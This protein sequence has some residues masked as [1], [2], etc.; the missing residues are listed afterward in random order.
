MR[1]PPSRLFALA[2]M[3]VAFLLSGCGSHRHEANRSDRERSTETIF[4]PN[5]EPLNGGPLGYPTCTD[6]MTGWFNRVDTNHDRTIDPSEFL[7]DTRRQ[8]AV[9]DLDHDGEITPDELAAYRAPY[10][11][12][13]PETAPR[14][15][16]TSSD[17]TSNQPSRGSRRGR[18]GNA[19][20]SLPNVGSS[21]RKVD[22]S[23]DAADPVMSADVDLKFRVTLSEFLVYEQQQFTQLDARHDQHLTLAEIL[24]L[25]SK[26]N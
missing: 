19:G 22:L 21:A 12:G 20:S 15:A 23:N 9:M 13:L 11:L 10:D 5:G 24:A 2:A 16:D 8:F 14:D 1:T 6:A 3:L 26:A 7:T 17:Q 18:G 25:C 4:S